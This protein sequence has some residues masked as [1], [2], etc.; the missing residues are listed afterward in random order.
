MSGKCNIDIKGQDVL[1]L[2]DIFATLST[3]ETA[4][5]CLENC[6]HID[7][8]AV[9]GVF[10]EAGFARSKR[11]NNVVRRFVTTDTIDCDYTRA[12]VI[13]EIVEFYKTE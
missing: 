7:C 1:I 5:N 13:P 3:I 9:H 11:L 4:I 12:S 10:P 8:F 6:G 2:D